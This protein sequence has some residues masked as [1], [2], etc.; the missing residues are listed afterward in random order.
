M[1]LWTAVTW[2][3][4]TAAL[5]HSS[6]AAV[7]TKYEVVFSFAGVYHTISTVT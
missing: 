6:T 2:Q 5:T 3:K 1:F 4:V 7:Y